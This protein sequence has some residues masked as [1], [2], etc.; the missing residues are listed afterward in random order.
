MDAQ[1]DFE[2]LFETPLELDEE[3]VRVRSRDGGGNELMD[4]IA[5]ET[6]RLLLRENRLALAKGRS[7][8][9]LSLAGGN[10]DLTYYDIPLMCVAHPHPRCRFSW[11]RLIVDFSLTRGTVICD[12]SPREVKS[13]EPVELETKVGLD[14]KFE[15]TEGVGAEFTPEWTKKRTVYYPKIL[16]S[17]I[18]F[19]QGYWDFIAQTDDYMHTNREL[20]LLVAALKGELVKAQFN[21]SAEVRLEGFLGQIPLLSRT[22]EINEIYKL[23]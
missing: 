17:G 2:L 9:Q 6:V 13:K 23:T 15:I 18:N 5:D 7:R 8:P 20:R 14:L 22:P 10:P 4:I 3:E 16:S 12:M 19:T 11:V 21:L 1:D